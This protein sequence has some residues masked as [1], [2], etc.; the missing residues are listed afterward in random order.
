LENGKWNP[1]KTNLDDLYGWWETIQTADLD[2]DGQE[3]LILGNLGENF[4]LH[5]TPLAPVKLWLGDFDGNDLPDKVF[6]QTIE[7]KDVPVFLKREFTEAMPSFKKENLRHHAYAEKI[8][9]TLLKPEQ[10][11]N[12]VV[13]TFN[14]CSSIV[15]Y[16]KGNG[17]FEIQPLPIPAQ[18][19]NIQAILCT[20]VD[21]DG[22]TDLVLGGNLPDCLPQF[23]RLDANSGL[24]LRNKGNRILEPV[25]AAVTGIYSKSV[26][27]DIKEIK[28]NSMEAILFLRNNALPLLFVKQQKKKNSR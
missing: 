24:V 28:S 13:K 6:S 2:G 17:L 20:D 21:G 27:R 15:A 18:L 4:Y 23:G 3:D 26:V 7:G 11:K 8:I 19:S 12:A 1:V 14:F 16:K 10:I 5:P 25:S 22:K 9:Q